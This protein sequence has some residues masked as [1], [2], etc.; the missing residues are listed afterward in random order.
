MVLKDPTVGRS[1]DLSILLLFVLYTK[2]ALVLFYLSNPP[3]I[4][5]EVGEIW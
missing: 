2:E 5:I 1:A 4:R 3:N